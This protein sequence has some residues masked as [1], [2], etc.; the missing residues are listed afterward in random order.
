ML[1]YGEVGLARPTLAQRLERDARRVTAMALYRAGAA[2]MTET[3]RLIGV[4][5]S[6]VNR[7]PPK[8]FDWHEARAAWLAH[9]ME[10]TDNGGVRRKRGTASLGRDSAPISDESDAGHAS[11]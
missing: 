3:A 2:T 1:H 4:H 5:K 6:N 7:S 8:N 11:P 10:R 9:A